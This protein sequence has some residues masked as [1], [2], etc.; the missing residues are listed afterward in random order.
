MRLERSGRVSD[1][2]V[3]KSSG[4]KQFDASAVA[5]VRRA[6]PFPPVP[7][8]AQSSLLGDLRMVLDP[9]RPVPG[10]SQGKRLDL[11][12]GGRDDVEATQC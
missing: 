6:S 1:V 12:R 8:S 10:S 2:R 5:A 3:E 9:T 7:E 4:Q 11:S